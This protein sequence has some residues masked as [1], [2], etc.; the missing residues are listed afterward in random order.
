MHRALSGIMGIALGWFGAVAEAQ[1]DAGA[2][3]AQ[4]VVIALAQQLAKAPDNR[5]LRF[6]YA[7]ASYQTGRYDAA[8]YHLKVLMRT[9][10]DAAE[11]VQLRKAYATVVGAS[12]WSFS[13][14]LSLLPSTNVSKVSSNT[15]FDTLL[16]QFVIV[17]GGE[18]ES[19]VGVR[20]GGRLSYA[21]MLHDGLALTFSLAAN[22]NWYPTERFRR[23][24][25]EASATLG[26]QTV[27]GNTEA[28]PYV[29]RTIYDTAKTSNATRYGFRLS[30][31]H[32]LSDSASL[33]GAVT[34]EYRDYDQANYL[35]GGFSQGV[36]TY[37]SE[38]AE[39]YSFRVVAK[40][41]RSMPE[42]DYLRYTGA[43]LSGEI[44]RSLGAIGTLGLSADLGARQYDG[45]FPA[46][47]EARN[48]QFGGLGVSFTSPHLK[49]WELT[50]K[51]SCRYGQNRSNVALY[52]FNST[53]CAISFEHNF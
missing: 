15:T 45:I 43:S 9:S 1:G 27:S 14:N 52:E 20:F 39:T 16:G 26:W 7:Q 53:D 42:R 19:G 10:D 17:D 35:D 40:L 47:A 34:A 18:E 23:Y 29:A 37:S 32:Y 50:P 21:S 6:R 22:R 28:K 3:P 4:Q 12:P 44:S 48:D 5:A 8:K 46:L 38:F 51:L 30:H 33:T 13:L 2:R 31:E 25:G 41:E 49:V 11:L 36:L 24:D